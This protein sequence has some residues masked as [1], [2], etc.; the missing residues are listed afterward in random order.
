[1]VPVGLVYE[2]S[3]VSRALLFREGIVL[4]DGNVPLT[5][6][7]GEDAAEADGFETGVSERVDGLLR[8]AWI[9]ILILRNDTFK[10][11]EEA[12]ECSVIEESTD[13]RMTM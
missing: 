3:L 7:T 13:A 4:E 1:M 11:A 12:N 6:E 5:S 2:R 8:I 10:S 9:G